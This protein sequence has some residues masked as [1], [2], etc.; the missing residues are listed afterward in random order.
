MQTRESLINARRR[1]GVDAVR[2]RRRAWRSMQPSNGLR[3]AAFRRL[4]GSASCC[5]RTDAMTHQS[6][7]GDV[8]VGQRGLR[9]G[10]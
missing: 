6:P 3:R 10:P 9:V 4:R 7:P 5:R 1:R 8:Q 2:H